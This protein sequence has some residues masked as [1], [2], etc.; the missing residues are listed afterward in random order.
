MEK[1]S[2]NTFIIIIIIITVCVQNL[3]EAQLAAHHCLSGPVVKVLGVG[4]CSSNYQ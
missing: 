2:R 3:S 1:Y 4:S